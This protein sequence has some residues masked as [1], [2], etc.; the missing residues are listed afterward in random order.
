MSSY[1]QLNFP[2]IDYKFWADKN[3][4]FSKDEIPTT[5]KSGITSAKKGG[6]LDDLKLISANDINLQIEARIKNFNFDESHKNE[7]LIIF[8]LIQAWGEEME[9]IHTRKRQSE[10]TMQMILHRHI[11]IKY[12]CSFKKVQVI[13]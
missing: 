4:F 1:E 12:P 10:L 5:I 3:D 6:L 7:L 13:V 2:R 8:D 11:G 9:D